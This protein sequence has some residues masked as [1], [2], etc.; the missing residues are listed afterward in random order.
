MTEQNKTLVDRI[1]DLFASV[2]LAVV[3][4]AFIALSSIVGTVLEQRGE[5][6]KNLLIL[7]KLFGDTLAPYAYRSFE[8]LGFLDMYDSWWFVGFLVLFA[9][10]LTICSLDR[11]PRIFKLV[12]EPIKP[13]SPQRM[14]SFSLRREFTMK[15]NLATVDER[16]RKSMKTLGFK[17]LNSPLE[18]GGFQLYSQKGSSTRL[19]VYITHLSILLILVGAVIG[20][21]LGF[22]GFLNLPEGY[23]SPVAYERGNRQQKE[24]GFSVRCDDFDVQFYGMSEAPKDYRSWLTVIKDGKEVMK[25]MIEVNEPLKYEGYTFYQS[26]YGML[27]NAEGYFIFKVTGKGQKKEQ[28]TLQLGES[29]SI[30]GTDIVGKV[31]DFSPALATDA[32]GSSYTYTDKMNNPA[33]YIEFSESGKEKYKGWVLK[34]FPKTW[35]L[36]DDHIVEFVDYWGTQYT[37]L[38]VRKDPGVW[39]VYLGCA[40]MSIGLYMTFFMSH[41]KIWIFVKKAGKNSALTVMATANKN[42]PSLE[43]KIETFVSG[44][45]SQ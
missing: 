10:N 38:Q 19:G 45:T 37:G 17:P 8:S 3:L 5:P 6:E 13:L 21:S 30:S 32:S 40:I 18:D 12:R 2:K 44:L 39:I 28:I 15:G 34:R 31:T 26:S 43:R 24:L 4:F 29:F 20:I 23:A 35:R 42:R 25:K 41:R 9:A 33:A 22:N 14:K 16:L 27:P 11:L 1:W 7:K 36:P